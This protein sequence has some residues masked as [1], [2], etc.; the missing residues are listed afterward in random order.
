M[1]RTRIPKLTAVTPAAA[2]SWFKRMLERG[3]QFHPDDDPNEIVFISDGTRFFSDQEC[4]QLNEYVHRLFAALGDTVYELAFDV[5]SVKFHT[6][7][8][9]RAF[10]AADA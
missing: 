8:E 5:W 3:L 1:N 4:T 6:R 10:L 2:K 9:R 7:A